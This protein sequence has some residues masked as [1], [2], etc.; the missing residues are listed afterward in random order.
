MTEKQQAKQTKNSNASFGHERLCRH[1]AERIDRQFEKPRRNIEPSLVIGLFGE[2]GSGKSH[3][4]GLLEEEYKDYKLTDKQLTIPIL[5][6]PWRFEKEEHLIIPLMKTTELALNKCEN[7]LVTTD[8]EEKKEKQRHK[9]AAEWAGNLVK[10]TAKLFGVSALAVISSIKTKVSIP[11]FSETEMEGGKLVETFEKYYKNKENDKKSKFMGNFFKNQKEDEKSKFLAELTSHYFNF[12]EMLKA[13]TGHAKANDNN[14]KKLNLLFLIDDIDRCLPEKAV[15]MLESI[16]LFLDVEGCAF[17]LAVDDEVVERGIVHRYRDYIFQQ[18]NQQ[19]Q[20]KEPNRP[21]AETAPPITGAEYL[22]KIIHL[23]FR[24][25]LPS[26]NEIRQ[27]LLKEF[28][29]LFSIE[30]DHSTEKMPELEEQ[31]LATQKEQK[32]QKI[33]QQDTAL[34]DLFVR[35]VPR[36]P[37]KLIRAVELFQL[38]RDIMRDRG[39]SNLDEL[40]L[41]RLVILQLLLPDLYRFGRQW[42][43]FLGTLERW[44]RE[45]KGRW[46]LPNMSDEKLRKEEEKKYKENKQEFNE[47]IFEEQDKPLLF[48]VHKHSTLR[49][50][51]N[52][53]K[54][55]DP[56]HPS[57]TRIANYFCLLDESGTKSSPAEIILQGSDASDR[58][59]L[60]LEDE[61]KFIEY[62]S[63][64]RPDAWTSAAGFSGLDTG[65]MSDELFKQFCS[66]VNAPIN[67]DSDYIQEDWL[68]IVNPL[69]TTEQKN[70][71]WGDLRKE[72]ETKL[73]DLDIEAKQRLIAG[74]NLDALGDH[75]K[76]VGLNKQGLPDIEWIEIPAGEFLYGEDNKKQT[77]DGFKIA[78][79]PITNQQFQA[80]LDDINANPDA[81]EKYWDG[82]EKQ[83]FES[84]RFQ[85]GNRPRE[86]VS[87][88]QAVAFTRW[89]SEKTGE[90]IQ[91]PTEQQWEKAARGTD[92]REY[93]WGNDFNNAYVNSHESDLRET[94]PVGM[95]DKV[96]SPY[97]VSEMEG[98][99]WE[100]CEDRYDANRDSRV[101]RG[102]SWGSSPLNLRS[103]NRDDDLPG[104][105]YYGIGFR[106]FCA[107]P[108]TEN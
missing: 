56:K 108:F 105:R 74:N 66:S 13:A 1:L 33:T 42:Q 14:N 87:W 36:V 7:W 98:N 43:G 96:E 32:Q 104:A 9:E 35:A 81:A 67:S 75:R 78:K 25:P 50:G 100:W 72:L 99:V 3:L 41:A 51:F 30:Q 31:A 22:E 15:E 64:K 38:Q 4:L 80:F 20:A 84:S 17:V 29:E 24:L 48:L 21:V 10:G 82:L 65:V 62:I 73:V 61:T 18:Q 46:A 101:L 59:L 45:Y 12:H 68:R 71:L 47:T 95:Y 88:Y 103:A 11:G 58:P 106:I 52:L 55:I 2:W 53:R 40:T 26:E 63:S 94:N 89:L 69:L 86:R 28:P 23:P 8:P 85:Q 77:L 70:K 34:L 57:D 60:T 91:L 16:K 19:Y 93:P 6:N 37:R 27:F 90:K 102:G 39:M 44:E 107:P 83:E 97:G 79:Y 92:G 49:S 54:L 76:G 5:F